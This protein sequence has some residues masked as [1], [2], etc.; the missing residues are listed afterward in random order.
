M[1]KKILFT[2]LFL[3]QAIMLVSQEVELEKTYDIDGKADI[4]DNPHVG[5]SS[6]TGMFDYSFI[7]KAKSDKIKIENYRFDKDFNFVSSTQDEL[8]I[9]DAKS[10]YPWWNYKGDKFIQTSVTIDENDD[11]VL[12]TK[13]LNYSY[14]WKRLQY[15]FKADLQDKIKMKNVAGE[16]YFHYRNWIDP[17]NPD[18]LYILCGL[19]SKNDKLEYCR[20]FHLLKINKAIEIVK[21]VEIAFTYPQEIICPRY[22]DDKSDTRLNILKNNIVLVFAPRNEGSKVSDPNKTKYTYVML[23]DNLTLVDRIEFENPSSFWSIEDY[24][25]QDETNAVY[26]FGASMDSKDKYYDDLKKTKK[27]DGIEVM[28]VAEHK[29]AWVNDYSVSDLENKVVKSPST[30]KA[31]PYQGKKFMIAS[32]M[33]TDNGSLFI[34][35]QAY[36]TDA[37]GT[38]GNIMGSSSTSLPGQERKIK[39][40]D[41]FGIAFDSDGKVIGQYL[42]DMKGFMGGQDFSNFQFVFPGK[43]PNNI[44][45]LLVQPT[46]WDWSTFAGVGSIYT[47]KP[48]KAG[49]LGMENIGRGISKITCDLVSSSLGKVNLKDNSLTD[50]KNYQIDKDNR[51]SYVLSKNP[52]FMMTEDNKLILFGTQSMSGGK[53]LW[54]LKMRLD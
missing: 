35:G 17:D 3:F 11:L 32:Y 24:V 7:L 42:Y 49:D 38:M 53:R 6:E 44:Y 13:I 27:F 33:L 8:G 52:P 43:D 54:F 22:I 47:Y 19:K 50:F 28:R 46:Y 21:D 41:C 10:K 34:S 39:Y 20:K 15:T 36:F 14:N 45:W 31:E 29:I 2:L 5:Y 12:R 1:K 16:G 25:F 18:D 26:L 30:K 37:V 4:G 23:D 40:G 51:K 48:V 9:D